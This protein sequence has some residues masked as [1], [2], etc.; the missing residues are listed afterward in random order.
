[1]GRKRTPKSCCSRSYLRC[2][3]LVVLIANSRFRF[4]PLLP[5]LDGKSCRKNMWKLEPK[6]RSFRLNSTLK[7]N[8]DLQTFSRNF[9]A[10]RCIFATF[11]G[12]LRMREVTLACWEITSRGCCSGKNRNGSGI[13]ESPGV[14]KHAESRPTRT[15]HIKQKSIRP[16]A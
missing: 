2:S 3:F 13:Y 6:Q 15:T 11:G 8:F 7:S 12:L 16:W 9:G 4:G 5:C 10:H 1:M 14:P